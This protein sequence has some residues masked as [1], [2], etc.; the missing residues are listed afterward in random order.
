MSVAPSFSDTD[1]ALMHDTARRVVRLEA[2]MEGVTERLSELRDGQAKQ[3]DVLDKVLVEVRNGHGSPSPLRL[4]GSAWSA[5]AALV[6]S[7]GLIFVA[8]IR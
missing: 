4:S 6:S 7:L 8:L 2:Q 3:G 5:V 1:D